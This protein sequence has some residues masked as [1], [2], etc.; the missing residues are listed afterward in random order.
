MFRRRHHRRSDDSEIEHS[1]FIGLRAIIKSELLYSTAQ[2][3]EWLNDDEVL[4]QFCKACDYDMMKTFLRI[5]D[6]WLW[7]K[8]K[9]VDKAFFPN[10]KIWQEAREE[11][12]D[13]KLWVLPNIQS[14]SHTYVVW[15]PFEVYTEKFESLVIYTMERARRMVMSTS[16]GIVLLVDCVSNSGGYGMRKQV[17]VGIVQLLMRYYPQYIES[18]VVIDAN[19]SQR[20]NYYMVWCWLLSK[21]VRRKVRF[22]RRRNDVHIDW[23]Q[24]N[25]NEERV[26]EEIGGTYPN[27]LDW[28]KYMMDTVSLVP[29][30]ELTLETSFISIY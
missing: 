27:S 25:V 10:S 20:I 6:A 17:A 30:Q 5:R 23:N 3:T 16:G 29:V 28:N 15:R 9:H 1:L 24:Y 12:A 11:G 26:P 4:M 8:N 22:C 21:S 19:L 14:Q 13:G 7:R 18:I 2:P